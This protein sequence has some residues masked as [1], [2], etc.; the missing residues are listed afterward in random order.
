MIEAN[1]LSSAQ[2]FELHEELTRDDTT[3]KVT[4][5]RYWLVLPNARALDVKDKATGE[6]VFGVFSDLAVRNAALQD[7]KANEWFKVREEAAD[8]WLHDAAEIIKKAD[9]LQREKR[10]RRQPA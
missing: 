6:M 10:A 8:T 3:N 4:D 9:A 5:S 1:L 7:E 2:G